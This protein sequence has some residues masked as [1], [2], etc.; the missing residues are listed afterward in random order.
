MQ[1]SVIVHEL[2]IS[3]LKLHIQVQSRVVRQFVKQIQCL[4]LNSAKR[5]NSGKSA[6]RLRSISLT[7]VPSAF[8]V[9]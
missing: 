2:H 6:S 8:G 9:N 7:V 4:D 5:A 3:R 1:D